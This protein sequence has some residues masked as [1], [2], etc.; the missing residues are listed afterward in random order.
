MLSLSPAPTPNSSNVAQNTWSPAVCTTI[1]FLL[2]FAVSWYLYEYIKRHNGLEKILMHAFE[3]NPYLKSNIKLGESRF[4]SKCIS[5]C[6][7]LLVY[8]FVVCSYCICVWFYVAFRTNFRFYRAYTCWN[9]TLITLF[10]ILG[11]KQSLRAHLERQREEHGVCTEADSLTKY[12]VRRNK[13]DLFHLIFGNILV[14]TTVIVTIVVWAILYPNARLKNPVEATEHY[15]SF[16]SISQHVLNFVFV[17]FDFYLSTM[18]IVD[19]NMPFVL[20]FSIAYGIIFVIDWFV[21]GY[22][23]YPFLSLDRSFAVLFLFGLFLVHA[24]L[25][26]ASV[27]ISKCKSQ[28][29]SASSDRAYDELSKNPL[30]EDTDVISD[31]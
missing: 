4:R 21:D 19:G 26:K 10:F 22:A 24:G 13:Y 8:R 23:I 6:D 1:V 28:Q 18:T 17:Q 5:S 2:F 31:V 27:L 25:F 11:V 16:S 20:L 3:N 15:L 14:T 7:N 9:W 29:S 12:D 30:I